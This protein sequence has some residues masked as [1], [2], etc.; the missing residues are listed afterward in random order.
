[1]WERKGGFLGRDEK[2]K[3]SSKKEGGLVPYYLHWR[4]IDFRVRT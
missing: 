4:E 3:K 2:S 1:L